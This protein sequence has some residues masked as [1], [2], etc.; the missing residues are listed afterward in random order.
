M[1]IHK[2]AKYRITARIIALINFV[3]LILRLRNFL[4]IR[5]QIIVRAYVTRDF[6]VTYLT[7]YKNTGS[8]RSDHNTERAVRR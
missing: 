1:V 3:S 5:F 7:S 2:A 6:L 4:G 8:N